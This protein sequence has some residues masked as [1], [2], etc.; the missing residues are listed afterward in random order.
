MRINLLKLRNNTI[1]LYELLFLC[2]RKKAIL[3]HTPVRQIRED[4]KKG[5]YVE[6]L[7]EIEVN[8]AREVIQLLIQVFF[9]PCFLFLTSNCTLFLI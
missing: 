4:S 6:N 9:R 8:Y 1:I 2:V 5:V 3:N 7:K